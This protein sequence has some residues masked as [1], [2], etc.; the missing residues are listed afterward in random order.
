[1]NV[2]IFDDSIHS[3]LTLRVYY[4]TFDNLKIKYYFKPQLKIYI[5]F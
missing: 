5:K 4:A 1:M 2:F 3:L